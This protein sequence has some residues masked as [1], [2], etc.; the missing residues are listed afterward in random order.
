MQTLEKIKEL[1]SRYGIKPQSVIPEAT[2][3]SFKM[4]SEDIDDFFTH[5]GESFNIDGNGY[6]YY[7]YFLEQVHPLHVVRDIF[8]QIFKPNKI[9]KKPLTIN[10]LIK[11]AERGHWFDP[12]MGE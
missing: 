1:L 10:H 9:K 6:N 4:V 8:Y 3:Q 5:F 11:V 2:L 7:D 12:E